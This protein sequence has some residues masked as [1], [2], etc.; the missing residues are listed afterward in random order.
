MLLGKVLNALLLDPINYDLHV[1]RRL[2]RILGVLDDALGPKT[3]AR[4]DD[5]T[6][7]ARGKPYTA[8]ETLVFNPS[9]DL[10]ELAGLHLREQGPIDQLGRLGA[11]FLRRAAREEAS[12]EVDLASYILFDG[13]YAERLIEVGRRDA[14]RRADEI[15]AFFG[16]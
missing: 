12:W 4:V 3:R 6:R 7:D 5:V 13:R 1:L 15:R 14:H 16:R 2:N 9:A 11:W 10:G 8:I